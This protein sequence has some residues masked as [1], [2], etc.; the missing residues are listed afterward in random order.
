VQPHVAVHEREQVVRFGVVGVLRDGGL[1][2][3]QRRLVQPAVVEGL[4]LIEARDGAARIELRRQGKASARGLDA[5]A[6]LL[7]QAQVNEG[8]D[9]GRSAGKQFLEGLCGEVVPAQARVGPAEFPAGLAVIGGAT[10]AL[11]QLGHAAIV[12]AAFPVGQL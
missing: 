10:E 5:A 4:P 6:R 11:L 8:R 1:Q 7:G 2:R 3:H 9:I 12:E